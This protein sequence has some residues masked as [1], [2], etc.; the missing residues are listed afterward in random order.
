MIHETTLKLVLPEEPGKKIVLL[1]LDGVGGLP[2]PDT[3]ETELETA[4]LPNLDRLAARSS[5]GRMQVIAPGVTPGSGPAHLALFG[6]HPYEVEFGRGA[7]EALGSGFDLEPGDVAARANFATIDRDG[8]VRDRR[9]GR[10]PDAENRRLSKRLADGLAGGVAGAQVFVL[11]GKEHRFTVVFRGPGLDPGLADI[12][13]QREGRPLPAVSPQRPEAARTGAV[14]EEFLRR[15]RTILE[16]EARANGMLVRGF[17][18]LPRVMPF[19]ERY[20][21]RAGAIAAY[22]MYRGVAR[23]VGM[24]VLGVPATFE[25]ELS[26]LEEKYEEHDFFFVHYKGTDTAGHSGDFA[27]KVRHLEIVDAAIPRLEKLR[28]EVLI[29]TGDHSTPS[30]HK[31]HSWHPVPTLI[32]SPLAISGEGAVYTERSLMRGDLGVFPATDLLPLALAHASRLSKFG[33]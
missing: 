21:L 7:L 22:P 8:T 19:R 17:S 27:E 16:G 13:P 24:E 28:P 25:E 29:V 10:P 11:P 9:A 31:E 1:V 26:L 6:Y 14:V 12:D 15:S 18:G 32:R 3:G 5:G 20:G 2:H 30:I 33:A 23:L 4:H